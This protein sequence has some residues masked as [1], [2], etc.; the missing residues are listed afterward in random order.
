MYKR[1]GNKK[2]ETVIVNS[3]SIFQIIIIHVK[4]AKV[5]CG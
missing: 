3:V 5:N 4:Y 2:H 1:P